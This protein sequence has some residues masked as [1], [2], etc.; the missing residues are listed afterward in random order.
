MIACGAAGDSAGG[1]N[2]VATTPSPIPPGCTGSSINSVEI[3][4]FPG[5][6]LGGSTTGR[7]LTAQ[8]NGETFTWSEDGQSGLKITRDF[9]VC[10][11]EI[12]GELRGSRTFSIAFARSPSFGGGVGGVER[13]SLVNVDGPFTPVAGTQCQLTFTKLA[14]EQQPPYTFKVRFRISTSN[15]CGTGSGTGANGFPG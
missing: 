5:D 14:T 7:S 3:R 2:G 12:T 9:I 4:V 15:G 13:G 1:G 10:D 8:L 11:Y 6:S